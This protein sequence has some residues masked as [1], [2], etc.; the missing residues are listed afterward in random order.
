MLA[1]DEDSKKG[2]PVFAF[3]KAVARETWWGCEFG[4][5]EQGERSQN[6]FLDMLV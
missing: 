6:Y 5:K 2:S 3:K 4:R 1:V